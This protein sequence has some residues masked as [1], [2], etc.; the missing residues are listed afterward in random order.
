MRYCPSCHRCFQD[1]VE[2]C[3]FDQAPTREGAG[4]PLIIDGKYQL[5]SL[6]AH[7]GMGSVYRALHLQL[8]RPV[9]VKILR[10]EFLTDATVR[11][12]FHREALAAA[13]LKHPNII[14]VYDFGS[15]AN[16]SAYIV[17]ELVEG[18]SLREELR[19]L[20]ARSFQMRPERVAAVMRQV[21][22]GVEAAHRSGII[23]RDLKP[24]N[25]MIETD[26]DGTERV[27]VLD[28]G[29]AKLK[30]PQGTVQCLTDE[31]TIIGTPNYISPEQC[32][33][34][35]VDAR[36]DVY[37]LG[38][39]LYEMLTGQV[40]FSNTSTSAVLLSHLQEAPP[41]PTRFC[42][43]LHPAIERVVLRALAKSPQH[44]FGSAALL[45]DSLQRAVALPET[46]AV[47]M[48]SEEG[49]VEPATRPRQARVAMPPP[50][51]ATPVAAPAAAVAWL[52]DET[53]PDFEAPVAEPFKLPTPAAIP[54]PLER[55]PTLLL[56][57]RPRRGLYVVV[58]ALSL[59]AIGVLAD[60]N[61]GQRRWLQGGLSGLVQSA[62]PTPATPGQSD[63][64]AADALAAAPSVTPTNLLAA[65]S[66]EPSA[67]A[68]TVEATAT[69]ASP[70]PVALV[71]T[72]TASAAVSREQLKA[73]YR[74]WAETAMNTEWAEH[75]KFYATQ[76][77]YY[78]EGAMARTQVVARKRRV[79]GGLNKYYL[80]FAGEPEIA[81]K[82]GSDPPAAELTFDKQW[83]LQRG[84][85]RTAGKALTQIGLRFENGQW[86]IVS[87]KQLKLYHQ[88]ASVNRP[89]PPQAVKAHAARA[90]AAQS[91]AL[92]QRAAKSL[93][94]QRA[95]N[96]PPSRLPTA[97]R[98]R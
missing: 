45:A 2:F 86:Q 70:T 11:E 38:V 24:D 58:V 51:V 32:T 49:L 35:P 12:R 62:S 41:P 73:F 81:L 6:I 54:R 57:R 33:G 77:A 87:E 3:L 96:L 8:E 79:F 89:A 25:I 52:A 91:R 88:S 15:L 92:K 1:G 16:G 69:V 83:D 53:V 71:K 42:T 50:V 97:G 39:I 98:A 82:P 5:E 26:P 4:L 13:R 56:E 80:R 64:L 78:N 74:R 17:M 44:R 66:P 21:C 84:A 61:S 93:W 7:G 23:H 90:S 10:A 48:P 20:S 47:E 85:Q 28:F 40:P 37:A 67:P 65:K 63:E 29:I 60:F 43:G 36:S 22:A 18:R 46:A 76:V 59:L 55:E 34:L 9:A 27:L 95:V 19:L 30:Q 94:W 31:E 68:A 75:A 72:S 14:Q